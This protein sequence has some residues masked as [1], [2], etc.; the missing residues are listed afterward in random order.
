MSSEPKSVPISKRSRRN[1]KKIIAISLPTAIVLIGL[2]LYYF[3]YE[4]LPSDQTIKLTFVSTPEQSQYVTEYPM[5]F[6]TSSPNGIATD[7]Q[8]NVWFALE[9]YTAIGELNPSNNTIHLFQLP[10]SKSTGLTTWGVAVDKT[11]HLVWFTDQ[12]ANSIWS[13]NMLTGNFTKY[14]LSTKYA[15]PYQLALDNQGNVWFT[16]IFGNK[17]GEVTTQGELTEFATPTPNST[18]LSFGPGP[19]GITVNKRNNEVWFTESFANRV[20]HISTGT[21]SSTTWVI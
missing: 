11:R 9:N 14:S 10:E 12:N 20:V 21:F 7:S 5:Q 6:A 13:F 16:E 1:R 15:F 18:S 17:I 2:L 4:L 19:S 3:Y 8:G